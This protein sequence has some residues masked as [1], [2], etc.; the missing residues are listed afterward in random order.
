MSAKQQS[1][2][3]MWNTQTPSYSKETQ[4]LLKVMMKESKLNNFQTRQLQKTMQDGASLPLSCNPTTSAKPAQPVPHQKPSAR[5]SPMAHGKGVRSKEVIEES[6][7]YERPKYPG[8]GVTKSLD[9]EKERLA[10]YMAYGEDIP[11][12]TEERKREVLKT[13]EPEPI[14]DRFADLEAEI[15]ERVEFLEDM[16]KLGKEKHY[17]TIINT[18]ISQKIREMEVIDKQRTQQL[19]KAIA[20]KESLQGS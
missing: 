3:G 15:Q 18:E 8:G 19:K 13:P 14:I 20:E 11:P 4:E 7:A 1:K 6:G 2:S 9:K 16:R 17:K 10:N 5:V 12:I